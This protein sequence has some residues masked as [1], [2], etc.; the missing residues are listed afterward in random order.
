MVRV[1]S[2]A[3]SANICENAYNSA[4]DNIGMGRREKQC[5]LTKDRA[6]L[7]DLRPAVYPQLIRYE[8]LDEKSYRKHSK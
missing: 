1:C 8:E 5:G 3:F 4:K 2:F 6:R 7:Q